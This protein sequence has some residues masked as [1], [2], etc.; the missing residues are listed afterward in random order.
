MLKVLATF[1]SH[2]DN[3]VEVRVKDME[4]QKCWKR[5][6]T[7]EIFEGDMIPPAMILTKE[8][9]QTFLYALSGLGFLTSPESKPGVLSSMEQDRT[10]VLSGLSLHEEVQIK[11]GVYV[12]KVPSG[13]IYQ[14]GT[15]LQFVPQI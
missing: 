6:T 12:M 7:E 15:N 4:T 10:D 1:S 3:R 14:F 9:A 8:E 2:T 11:P 13:W 5:V